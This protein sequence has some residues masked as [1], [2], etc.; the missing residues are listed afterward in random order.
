MYF[1]FLS[2]ISNTAPYVLE[3]NIGLTAWEK[4]ERSKK[5]NQ[6]FS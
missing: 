4:R 6:L 2:R 5:K 1:D 3:D